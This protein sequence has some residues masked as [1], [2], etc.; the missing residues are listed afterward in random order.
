MNMNKYQ[1]HVTDNLWN[2]F[3]LLNEKYYLVIVNFSHVNLNF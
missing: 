1:L 2:I 3:C